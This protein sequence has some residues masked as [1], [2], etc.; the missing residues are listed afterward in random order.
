MRIQ[1]QTALI[2]TLLAAAVILLLNGIMYYSA[3]LDTAN[4]FKKR[5][6]LRV[7]VASK[8][9]FE[10]DTTSSATYNELRQQYLEMLPN[11]REFIF[12][13]TQPIDSIRLPN[14][15]KVPPSYL[16]DMM[17]SSET[18]YYSDGE[19]YFAGIHYVVGDDTYFI[20]KSAVNRFGLQ[21]LTNLR[22]ILAAAFV[23]K[24]VLVFAISFY[25]SRKTFKPFRDIINRVN[26]I[27]VENLSLRLE[28][29]KGKDEI[30][31]LTGTFNGMLDRLQ[32]AFDIQNNFV[33]NASHELKTPLTTIIGEAEIVLAKERDAAA[34]R[35]SLEVILKEAEKLEALT[36]A[37]LS[38]AQS[39]FNN[40]RVGL[41]QVRIDELLY[42]IHATIYRIHPESRVQLQWDELPADESQLTLRAN[43]QLLKLAISNIILNACK[44]SN[45]ETVE[46]KLQSEKDRIRIRITDHGIGIP[47]NEVKHVFVP[48][49]RASNTTSF[50]GYGVGLP[51]SLNIIRQHKGNIHVQ[52]EEGR[53]TE[54]TVELPLS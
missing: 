18:V 9:Y 44:Y 29:K 45:N 23:A 43:P 34:Y 17:R 11:E 33:S 24:V 2:F 32:T 30:A 3:T 15:L 5:L 35:Q 14:G 37:L 16:H 46:V 8:I 41:E 40:N 47:T 10:K 4:D 20:I 38:L 21:A 48:F 42:D 6:E 28:E 27:G 22:K 51:L 49:F 50:K 31:E 36:S 19:T 12:P 54:V 7:I 39:G 26:S 52:S 25:F 13:A 53:G 1:T